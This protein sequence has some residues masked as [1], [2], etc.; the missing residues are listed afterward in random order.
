M[1]LFDYSL[2]AAPIALV[3]AVIALVVRRWLLPLV[4]GVVALPIGG[5]AGRYAWEW[6]AEHPEGTEFGSSFEGYDWVI[7]FAS[8]GALVGASAGLGLST[9]RARRRRAHQLL[10]EGDPPTV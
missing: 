6:L 10:R 2:W 4:V 3:V 1:E 5:V 7:G 9:V 8:V